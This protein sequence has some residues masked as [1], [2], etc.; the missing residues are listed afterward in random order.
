M[1]IAITGATG[2]LGRYV[3]RQLAHAGH[4]L[5]CWYRP[6]SDRS[7]FEDVSQA[8]EW[9]PGESRGGPPTSRARPGYAAAVFI[10]VVVVVVVEH[11]LDLFKRL[12][13]NVGRI[14]H[15]GVSILCMAGARPT[16]MV[17]RCRES[18]IMAETTYPSLVALQRSDG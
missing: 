3:V 2:F 12:P 16:T 5:R 8:I 13:A 1:K 14:L 11:G 7:E 15:S 18:G 10:L 17:S 4:H 6:E 9:L